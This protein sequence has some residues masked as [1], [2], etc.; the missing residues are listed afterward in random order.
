MP[1]DDTGKPRAPLNRQLALQQFVERV[2]PR[3][4]PDTSQ[5]DDAA[6][7]VVAALEERDVVPLLLKGRALSVLLY[8]SGEHRSYS[9]VDLLVGP[10]DLAV[11]QQVLAG[12]GYAKAPSLEDVGGVI[13]A[14][15]WMRT[16]PGT[17]SLLS[18]DLHARL[19]GAR[20]EPEVVWEAL[21][22]HRIWID[23]SGHRAAALDRPGQAMHLALHAAQ[24]GAGYAK[25]LEELSLALERWPDPIWATAASLAETVGGLQLFAAGLRL[26]Q[27]GE[28]AAATLGLPATGELDWALRNRQGRPRG[29][30]H[31][32]AMRE[33]E[34]AWDALGI[35]RRSLLPSRSWIVRE[36]RWAAVSPLLLVTAYAAHVVRTPVWALRAFLYRKRANRNAQGSQQS[37]R[38]D[39][40]PH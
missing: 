3:R 34:S 22:T 37:V 17:G 32:Q 11:A 35:L 40:A 1:G 23:V 18:L 10:E 15:V 30:F 33:A 2:A 12:L 25:H 19:P 6:A 5:I 28:L 29:T 9:D 38:D 7:K 31:L 36:H 21:G 16:D 24:H 13:H 26:V 8:R 14:T 20:A 39:G 4:F 27:E